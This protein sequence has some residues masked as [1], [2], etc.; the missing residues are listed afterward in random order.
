MSDP[1]PMLANRRSPVS[2]TL[3]ERVTSMASNRVRSLLLSLAEPI[4]IERLDDFIAKNEGKG[5]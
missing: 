4:Q 5:R 2:E 3:L 1:I